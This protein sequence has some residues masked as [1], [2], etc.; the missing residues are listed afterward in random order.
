MLDIGSSRELCGGTHVARTG[1]IGIFKVVGESGV[2]AGVRRI[3]AVTGQNALAYLQNL[4]DTV[5]AAA[6]TLTVVTAARTSTTAARRTSRHHP[7]PAA[8]RSTRY[9]GLRS[10]PV[11][12]MALGVGGLAR[13]WCPFRVC[14]P[15]PRPHGPL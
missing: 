15:W 8:G 7:P 10:R 1:D 4:E 13:G 12:T 9:Q 11:A 5:G 2:A 14:W 6:A 3:E